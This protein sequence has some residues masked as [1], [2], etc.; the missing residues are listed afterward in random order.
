[1]RADQEE[2]AWV[3]E[4]LVEPEE[5]D[6]DSEPEELVDDSEELDELDESDE[7]S[8]DEPDEEVDA[9]SEDELEPRE[10]LR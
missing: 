5:L 8:P 9:P 6:E 1:M 10:S 3:P 4:E 2:A 7:D